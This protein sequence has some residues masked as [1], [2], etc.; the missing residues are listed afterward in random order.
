M[1]R[2]ALF[3]L[4]ALVLVYLVSACQQAAPGAGTPE[5]KEVTRV[6]KETVVVP[7]APSAQEPPQRYV[8]VVFSAGH[9]SWNQMLL[10]G[11]DV[12]EALRLNATFEGPQGPSDWN[13]AAEL[14][15][16]DQ[17][18]ATKPTGIVITSADA[19]T[20]VPGIERAVKAGIT[21]QCLDLKANTPL[22]D[23]CGTDFREMGVV[24]AHRIVELCQEDIKTKGKCEVGLTE[25]AG[26]Y[27]E[28]LRK[29]G[30]Y[31]VLKDY[32]QIQIVADVDD[33]SIPEMTVTVVQQMLAAHPDLR[34]LHCL[35]GQGAAAMAQAVKNA[36]KVPNKDVYIIG[37]DLGGTTLDCIQAGECD[38][39]VG[40]DMYMMGAYAFLNCYMRANKIPRHTIFE[41]KYSVPYINPG[42]G[43]VTAENLG[44]LL[45]R[46]REIE[47]IF[48]K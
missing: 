26:V 10:A 18:A 36:G 1:K 40:Q 43:L 22:C 23:F 7:A 30:L 41:G 35:H 5:V 25:I 9:E 34:V 21:V 3:L 39:T 11:R 46:I 27:S 31:S 20:L 6:V 33:K 38:S 15:I 16:L 48:R 29:E 44:S 24:A 4:I 2:I 17:V 19:E 12:I 28:D 13:A 42:T 14:D 45:D 32:P 8:L 37:N 47:R